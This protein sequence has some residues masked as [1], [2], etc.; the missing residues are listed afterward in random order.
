MA[1]AIAET[2][3]AR[4]D[5]GRLPGLRHLTMGC[6]AV[7]AILALVVVVT[8]HGTTQ[9][10]VVVRHAPSFDQPIWPATVNG[11]GAPKHVTHKARPDVATPPVPRSWHGPSKSKVMDGGG[12]TASSHSEQV[13][14]NVQDSASN[15]HEGT[16][17]SVNHVVSSSSNK[18]VT[19]S[20][21]VHVS[22][23]TSQVAQSGAGTN[24]VKVR[25]SVHV[26]RTVKHS[27]SS[28]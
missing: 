28:G 23:R 18:V 17:V 26:S 9:A 21:S 13:N 11:H 16:N 5:R 19:S 25:T 7:A 20:G 6:A 24:S 10:P 12:N 1:Y 3:P 4:P 14:K 8:H 15:T 22:N 2:V 27:T